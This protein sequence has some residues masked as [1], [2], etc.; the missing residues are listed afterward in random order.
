MTAQQI[1]LNKL[2]YYFYISYVVAIKDERY[3]KDFLHCNLLVGHLYKTNPRLPEK[4]DMS[5]R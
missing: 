4:G 3:I 1:I 5:F 2:Y